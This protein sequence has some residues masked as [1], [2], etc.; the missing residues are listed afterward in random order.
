M[1]CSRKVRVRKKIPVRGL[2]NTTQARRWVHRPTWDLLEVRDHAPA[3]LRKCTF[4]LYA[5][6]NWFI[7]MDVSRAMTFPDGTKHG[8]HDQLIHARRLMD[9]SWCITCV[10][11]YVVVLYGTRGFRAD[12]IGEF[13]DAHCCGGQ[14]DLSLCTSGIRKCILACIT[15]MDR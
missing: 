6:R 7:I 12:Q 9:E 1:S 2:G 3:H 11:T 15:R 14:Q 10:V 5:V 8:K 13:Y 4:C